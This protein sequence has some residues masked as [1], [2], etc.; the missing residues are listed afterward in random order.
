LLAGI[1]EIGTILRSLVERN[2]VRKLWKIY[3]IAKSL[4]S[5]YNVENNMAT[6][7]KKHRI[8]S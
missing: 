7:S 5:Y 3:I 6:P 1:L 4:Q 8:N 2:M